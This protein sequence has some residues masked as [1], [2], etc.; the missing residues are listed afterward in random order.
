MAVAEGIDFHFQNGHWRGAA[1]RMIPAV[2]ALI[3]RT[4]GKQ[5]N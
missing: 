5:L 3:S 1:A 2:P 4:V